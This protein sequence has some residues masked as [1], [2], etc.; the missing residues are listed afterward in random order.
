MS[1]IF[2]PIKSDL[3]CNIFSIFNVPFKLIFT[4]LIT[5][6]SLSLE[7]LLTYI[8]LA[9]SKKY[10]NS[11]LSTRLISVIVAKLEPPH[12]QIQWSHLSAHLHCLLIQILKSYLSLLL[13]AF[14]QISKRHCSWFY[15]LPLLSFLS[16]VPGRNNNNVINM[17]TTMHS[18]LMICITFYG[19]TRFYLIHA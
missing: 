1:V 3:R 19:Q 15:S 12:S 2:E 7:K 17:I 16:L 13:E 9:L 6:I 4:P 10:S 14:H 18:V 5:H 8:V 11:L